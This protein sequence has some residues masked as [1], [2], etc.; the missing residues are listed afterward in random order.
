M[1]LDI[2]NV[3]TIKWLCVDSITLYGTAYIY[4]QFVSSFISGNNKKKNQFQGINTYVISM[5]W[6]SRSD[7]ENRYK[8][9]YLYT[10]QYDLK[11]MI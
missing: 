7:E 3:K 5:D 6:F 8:G 11:Y 10:R 1:A 2:K 4:K 9:L